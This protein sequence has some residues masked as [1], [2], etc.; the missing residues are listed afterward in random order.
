VTPSFQQGRFLRRTID[1]V[2]A[3]DY[4]HIEYRVVDGGSTDETIDV[5]KSYGDRFPWVCEKDR[6]QAHAINKGL[7]EATGQIRAYLNSDDLLRP[8]A[9]REAVELF[10]RHPSCDLV[11]GRGAH[12][13]EADELIRFYPTKP[14]SFENLM[15][16][17]CIS[18]PSAFW[19]SR[20]GDL[21][22]DFDES[23]GF[24]LD[25]DYWLRI[26]KA[27]GRIMDADGVWSA[28]RMHAE[29]KTC[30]GSRD[31]IY[32]EI[33]RTSTEH[34]GYVSH[35]AIDSWL[36]FCFFPRHPMLRHLRPML[37]RIL[38]VHSKYL[39]QKSP[40]STMPVW[41]LG[42]ALHYAYRIARRMPGMNLV[43]KM[44]P[45]KSEPAGNRADNWL[46]P[47]C[48][49]FPKRRGPAEEIRLVGAAA[50]AMRLV[51]R[52]GRETIADFELPAESVSALT[53]PVRESDEPVLLDFSNHVAGLIDREPVSFRVLGTNLYREDETAGS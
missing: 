24:A 36:R 17:C 13:D 44:F 1:S 22:G 53:L 46:A 14:Y 25:Y 28:T 8:G 12:I 45:P 23:Y 42:K 31:R 52:Q 10:R 30:G 50:A 20:I 3:Q 2:L 35:T 41:M 26:A 9:V 6:G 51:V 33:W 38:F 4:P 5:L 43:R 48:R 7:A 39:A 16:T 11:Y 34:G 40:T 19:R 37:A 18:Q 27:G 49:F 47:K 15:E 32:A 29:A 21:V